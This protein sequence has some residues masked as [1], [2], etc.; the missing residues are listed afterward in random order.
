MS[1]ARFICQSC[2]AIRRF[3]FTDAKAVSKELGTG[4]CKVC[5]KFNKERKKCKKKETKV[6]PYNYNK[7]GA[8]KI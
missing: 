4:Q 1:T 3:E 6:I 5:K 7:K 8:L 2:K